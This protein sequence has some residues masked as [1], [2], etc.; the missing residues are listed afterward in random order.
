MNVCNPFF[1]CK[2]RLVRN[3][4]NEFSWFISAP[5][6][7]GNA[8]FVCY[9]NNSHIYFILQYI[10]TFIWV[11]YLQNASLIHITRIWSIKQEGQIFLDFFTNRY[12]WMIRNNYIWTVSEKKID[13]SW[14][15]IDAHFRQ[16]KDERVRYQNIQNVN[17]LVSVL[18][19]LEICFSTLFMLFQKQ[20]IKLSLTENKENQTEIKTITHICDKGRALVVW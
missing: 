16:L 1:I 14:D 13:I 19:F 17:F 20:F 9:W 7:Y 4:A 6:R 3:I 18:Y 10:P 5:I 15:I 11:T 2:S 12:M 8:H